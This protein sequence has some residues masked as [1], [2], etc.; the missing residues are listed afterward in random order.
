M[1]SE[2]LVAHLVY[3]FMGDRTW[4]IHDQNDRWICQVRTFQHTGSY[5]VSYRP[6]EF[7]EQPIPNVKNYTEMQ[8]WLVAHHCHC[9]EL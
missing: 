1:N 2:N 4:D 7:S 3:S 5:D 8:R 6:E 9:E